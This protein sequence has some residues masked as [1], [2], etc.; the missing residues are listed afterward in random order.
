M[1]IEGCN[2]ERKKRVR[3]RKTEGQKHL[4][5]DTDTAWPPVD[6]PSISHEDRKG[7][8]AVWVQTQLDGLRLGG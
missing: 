1:R 7:R 5:H 2:I 8:G 4:C 3:A 6:G